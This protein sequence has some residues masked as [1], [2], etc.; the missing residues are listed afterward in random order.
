MTL[1]FLLSPIDLDHITQ[2]LEGVERQP[3]RQNDAQ[4]RERVLE[5]EKMG[6]GDKI[7]RKKVVIFKD[8]KHQTSGQD[9]DRQEKFFYFLTLRIFDEHP[10]EII[11][12]DGHCQYEDIDRD[13]SDVKKAARHKK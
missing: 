13:E 8:K 7:I 2:T 4:Y 11:D 6:D 3:D 10:G 12:Q 1:G 5:V 9:T